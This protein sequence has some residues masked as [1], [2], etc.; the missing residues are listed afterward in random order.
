[1]TNV[2]LDGFYVITVLQGK[3]SVGVPLWYIKDK[4]GKP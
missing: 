1:M 3:H 2:M 4:P